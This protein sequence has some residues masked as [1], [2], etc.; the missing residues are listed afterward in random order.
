MPRSFF[1]FFVLS[2]STVLL[3]F[4][5]GHTLKDI[6]WVGFQPF[7][8]ICSRLSSSILH[9]NTTA[10]ISNPLNS[11]QS[12]FQRSRSFIQ[13]VHHSTCKNWRLIEN[14][15][16]LFKWSCGWDPHARALQKFLQECSSMDLWQCLQPRYPKQ[17]DSKLPV[18]ESVLNE[19]C[20][21][22]SLLTWKVLFPESE[23][24][25]LVPLLFHRNTDIFSTYPQWN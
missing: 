6:R 3:V 23:L 5:L 13:N 20:V 22:L 19:L 17:T 25:V 16:N 11:L 7:M 8:F 9:G 2:L 24:G 18:D 14:Q 4:T 15:W 10:T 21:K 12:C 1:I